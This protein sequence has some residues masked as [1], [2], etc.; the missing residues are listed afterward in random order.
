MKICIFGADGRTGVE[1]VNYAKQQGH[2]VTAFVYSDTSNKYFPSDI[3]IKQGN[4]LDYDKVLDAI[5]GSEAVVSV[6]GHIKGSDPL[7]QTKGITN[8]VSAMN[9]LGV[10]R[11]LSL[12]GTGAREMDDKPSLVDVFLNAL[13]MLID[14]I[15]IQDAIQHALGFFLTSGIDLAA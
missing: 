2:E 6:I 8:I 10:K 7:M 5:R 13:V 12:T 11:I 15:R 14:P 9:I 3:I 4:I 1:V